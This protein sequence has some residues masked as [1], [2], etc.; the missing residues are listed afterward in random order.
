MKTR[1]NGKKV[2]LVALVCAMA[3]SL[4]QATPP[5]VEYI[6]GRFNELEGK[7]AE[8]ESAFAKTRQFFDGYLKKFKE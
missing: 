5:Q 3:V 4:A 7:I 6:L 8:L 1:Q 2:L